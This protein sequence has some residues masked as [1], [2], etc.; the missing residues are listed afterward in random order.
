MKTLSISLLL[1]SSLAFA[2]T[3]TASVA[4][5]WK[6][7]STVAGNE[8]DSSC[9]FVQK[10]N[11]LTGTCKSEQGESKLTGKVDGRKISWS[12]N[13]DYNGTALTITYSGTVAGDK[14]SGDESVDPFGVSGDFTAT[15]SR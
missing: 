8:S 3:E 11:E 10:D 14:I 5:T 2:Q 6:L 4:G 13:A 7:H 1:M 9:T 12:Y 15:L